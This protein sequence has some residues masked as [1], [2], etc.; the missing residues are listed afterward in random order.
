[1]S[2]VQLQVNRCGDVVVVVVVVVVVPVDVD[3]IVDVVFEAN[4]I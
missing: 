2:F 1:M 4:I 3:V